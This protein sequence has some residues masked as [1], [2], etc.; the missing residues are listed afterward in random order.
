VIRECKALSR[1]KDQH[2]NTVYQNEDDQVL[3]GKEEYM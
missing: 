3:T 1:E 2:K